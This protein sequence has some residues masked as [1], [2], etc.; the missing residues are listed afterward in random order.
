VQ[1]AALD[2]ASGALLGDCG[3]C[4]VTD[5]PRTAEVGVTFAPASQGRGLATEALAA[6]VA[7]LFEQHDMHR[8]FATADDRNHAVHRVFD[9]LGFRCEARHVDADWFKG[10]WATLRVYAL[11]RR[12][13]G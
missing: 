7:H 2:R 5:Q 12:D 9:R 10:E 13:W 3:V 6:V 8:L 4:V 11:L 1:V